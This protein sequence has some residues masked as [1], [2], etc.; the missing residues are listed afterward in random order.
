[1]FARVVSVVIPTFRR[2][3]ALLRALRSCQ[4]QVGI[5]L[6]DFEAVVVDNSSN[7][8]AQATVE[9]AQAENAQLTLRW[10]HEPV[11]GVSAARN[12]GLASAAGKLI[13]FL[14]DD[15]EAE[16]GWLAALV[17]AQRVSAAD[18]VFGAVKGK[19]EGAPRGDAALFEGEMTR[20][21]PE[22]AGP[23]PVWRV[24]SLGSG[25]S[26]FVRGCFDTAAPF[27]PALGL[28]GGEDSALIRHLI[29]EGKRLQWAPAARVIEYF[30]A[31]RHTMRFLL[32]RRFSAGQVRTSVCVMPEHPNRPEAAMW[33]ALGAVQAS[34]GA[35]LAVATSM[36]KPELSKRFLCVASGGLGKILWMPSFRVN[37]YPERKKQ[38]A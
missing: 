16:P 37:R 10:I 8:A 9:A 38:K 22:P 17:E 21:F 2:P 19:F 20:D 25:N 3:D 12:R 15:E 7:G 26:L 30:G 34:V 14:D 35:A 28:S 27:N 24:A 5:A 36:V 29:A 32:K 13:A 31:D 11:P 1:M 18:V 6:A 4:A 33:M 23:V